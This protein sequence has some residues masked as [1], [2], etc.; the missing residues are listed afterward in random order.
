MAKLVLPQELG[1]AAM[2]K[3]FSPEG[4]RAPHE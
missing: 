3:D 1:K 4:A 2:I